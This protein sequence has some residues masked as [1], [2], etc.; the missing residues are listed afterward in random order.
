[1]DHIV[2]TC[3]KNKTKARHQWL[4]PAILATQEAEIRRIMVQSQL[5]Q[6]FA[7]PYLEKKNNHKKRTSEEAQ[8]V[9]P[10]FKP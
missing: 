10:E 1:M 8:V 4:M 9:G 3:L 5:S 7:R 2:R 6:Q